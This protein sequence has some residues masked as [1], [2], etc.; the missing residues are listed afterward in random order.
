MHQ[1][2]KNAMAHYM[3]AQERRAQS[4]VNWH[5]TARQRAE[6]EKSR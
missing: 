3:A 5:Y 4:Y 6:M 2:L 1:I